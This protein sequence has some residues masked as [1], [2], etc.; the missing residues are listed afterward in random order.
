MNPEPNVVDIFMFWLQAS[1]L[2]AKKD[3]ELKANIVA[4]FLFVV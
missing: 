3:I 2:I 4:I 1:G